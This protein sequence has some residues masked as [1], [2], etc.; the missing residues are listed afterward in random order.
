MRKPEINRPLAR[1]R[2]KWENKIKINRNGT[3][4]WAWTELVWPRG[5]TG[6][7]ELFVLHDVWA[8]LVRLSKCEIL[9]NGPAPGICWLVG[10]LVVS[11]LR[12][13]FGWLFGLLVRS[14][15]VWMTVWL[16]GWLFG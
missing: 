10:W 8:G 3:F 7:G 11:F 12:S 13:L 1:P 6:Y 4:W 14:F 9:R 16:V 2:A 5:R 15:V